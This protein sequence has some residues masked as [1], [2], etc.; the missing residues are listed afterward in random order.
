M[1]I[2][3]NLRKVSIIPEGS[4]SQSGM[5]K[6]VGP[7]L[8]GLRRNPISR[9]SQKPNKAKYAGD[10]RDYPTLIRELYGLR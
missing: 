10:Y 2:M 5:L 9:S 3:G 1:G 7:G 8:C 4:R 6:G